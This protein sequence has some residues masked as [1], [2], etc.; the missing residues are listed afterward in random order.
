MFIIYFLIQLVLTNLD[1]F[2]AEDEEFDEVFELTLL[3]LI[4]D[5]VDL[6]SS[7]SSLIQL[8]GSLLI[9]LTLSEGSVIIIILLYILIIYQEKKLIEYTQYYNYPIIP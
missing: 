3:Q 4:V 1:I 5:V 2:L 6:T 8:G 7:S 9:N